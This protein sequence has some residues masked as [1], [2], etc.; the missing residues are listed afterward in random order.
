MGLA[1]GHR[2]ADLVRSVLSGVALSAR[3][4]LTVATDAAGRAPGPVHVGGRG[5]ASPA[6]AAA[7]LRGLGVSL[8]LHD[9]PNLSA[10]GAAMLGAAA[11]GRPLATTTLLREDPVRMDPTPEDV[12]RAARDF[13]AYLEASSV[14]QSWS[15][16]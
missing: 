13:A 4:V 16:S 12:E 2:A 1:A 11:T 5:V 15:R 7:R 14:A 8:L 9:E 6:W 10:L 3:H